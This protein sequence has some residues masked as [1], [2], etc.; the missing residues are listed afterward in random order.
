MPI[1][2]PPESDHE[3]DLAEQPSSFEESNQ[4]PLKRSRSQNDMNFQLKAKQAL[5]I[6]TE[7]QEPIA[8]RPEMK[9][10][11]NKD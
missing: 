9:R 5:Q 3:K 7:H 6:V 1:E 4:D 11:E 10:S 2:L 8:T